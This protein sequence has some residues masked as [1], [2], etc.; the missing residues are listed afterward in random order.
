MQVIEII[1]LIF[2]RQIFLKISKA[3]EEMPESDSLDNIYLHL[4]IVSL[5]TYA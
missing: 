2:F 3:I 4:M 5:Q 1:R